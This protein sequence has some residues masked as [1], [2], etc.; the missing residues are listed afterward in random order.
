MGC[1]LTGSPVFARIIPGDPDYA[2][3]KKLKRWH[4][5][6]KVIRYRSDKVLGGEILEIEPGYL[7]DFASVPWLLRRWFPQ[8]GPWTGAAVVHDKLCDMRPADISSREAADI[9]LEAMV[10]LHVGVH[11]RNI[12]HAGVVCFGPQWDRTAERRSGPPKG[13]TDT[14]ASDRR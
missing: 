13:G 1:F 10:D 3:A 14:S 6:E 11:S 2:R 5:V 8:D 4:R 12:M 7:T 9:F